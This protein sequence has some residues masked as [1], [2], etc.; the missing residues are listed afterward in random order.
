M[1]TYQMIA[2]AIEDVDNVEK[3]YSQKTNSKQKPLLK[4]K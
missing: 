4:D 1:K 2:F 3:A